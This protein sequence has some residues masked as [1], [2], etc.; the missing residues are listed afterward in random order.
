MRSIL[1]I[2]DHSAAANYAAKLALNIAQKVGANLILLNAAIPVSIL[3]AVKYESVPEVMQGGHTELTDVSLAEL[4]NLQNQSAQKFRPK[5]IGIDPALFLPDELMSFVHQ[6]NIWMVI[7]GIPGEEA[8]PRQSAIS[9]QAILNKTKCPMLLV[10]EQ[11]EIKDFEHIVH[12]T[13]LRY[14]KLQHLN[15]L[16]E[17]AKPYQAG[18]LLAHVT[19][20]DLPPIEKSYA[21]DIFNKEIS[22]HVRYPKL[23]F[24]LIKEKNL[25]KVYDV[26]AHGMDTDLLAVV[27]QGFHFEDIISHYKNYK[28]PAHITVPLLVFPY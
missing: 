5:I 11:P 3:P 15:Y 4:L 18:L 2:N 28:L 17:L 1:V 16:V 14:C 21:V 10:P 26:L 25:E 6:Q 24:D 13:D 20:S 8:F 22:S 9:I 7:K 23:F 27:N 12:T 19:M